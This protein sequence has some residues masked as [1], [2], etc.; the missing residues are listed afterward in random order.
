MT[1]GKRRK[2]KQAS[3]RVSR[4]ALTR[5][6]FGLGRSSGRWGTR[7][8]GRPMNDVDRGPSYRSPTT[9]HLSHRD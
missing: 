7:Q 4:L 3:L 2:E 5:L 9:N 8:A 1:D 6:E